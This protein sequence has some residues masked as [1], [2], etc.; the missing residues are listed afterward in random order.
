[1]N[2]P[3]N[4]ASATGLLKTG[5]GTDFFSSKSGQVAGQ[6][7]LRDDFWTGKQNRFLK[8]ETGHEKCFEARQN[9]PRNPVLS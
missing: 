7:F 4:L 3:I 2:A 5:S 9:W 6:D 8:E 1:V